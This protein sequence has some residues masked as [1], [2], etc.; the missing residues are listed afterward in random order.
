MVKQ[1]KNWYSSWFNTNYY[2]ILYGNRD[3]EEAQLFMN[4]LVKYLKLQKEASILD[5]GC[6]KGRHAIHLNRSGYTVTGIDLSA[7]NI[8][9]AQQYANQNLA[10]I[11]HDMRVALKQNFDAVFNLFTSF[12]YFEN[13][14][15]NFA[16]IKAIKQELKPGGFGVIDFMNAKLSIKNLVPEEIKT[17]GG[18]DFHISRK[19]EEGFI[20]K[21]INFQD[22]GEKFSYV[23]KVKA[24]TLEDFKT[25]F[26]TAGLDLINVFGDYKLHPFEEDKSERLILI[27]QA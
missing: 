17:I 18:I 23:E 24:L 9:V 14:E 20:I 27:F 26:K 1:S 2:H 11:R 6:G 5:L 19:V 13:E 3:F 7:N 15:D 12:G 22:E 21:N 8:E 16:T 10:F 4:N 25:Y